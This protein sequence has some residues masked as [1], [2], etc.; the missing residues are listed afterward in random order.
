MRTVYFLGA[1]QHGQT[2]QLF[3]EELE[4]SDE[5]ANKI[6]YQNALRLVP[7]QHT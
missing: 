6:F 7:L 2:L 1:I 4:L 3:L 5:V